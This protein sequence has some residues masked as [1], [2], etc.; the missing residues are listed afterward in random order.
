MAKPIEWSET[1]HQDITQTVRMT[2]TRTWADKYGTPHRVDDSPST[3]DI[4]AA[5]AAMPEG[6]RAEVLREFD[7]GDQRDAET[8]RADLSTARSEKAERERDE[9]RLER[10]RARASLDVV[11]HDLDGTRQELREA[12]EARDRS[13][14]LRDAMMPYTRAAL[15]AAHDEDAVTAARRVV[16]ERDSLRTRCIAAE[17]AL[18]KKGELWVESKTADPPK[19]REY[20]LAEGSRWDGDEIV[21][22]DGTRTSAVGRT[23]GAHIWCVGPWGEKR[24]PRLENVLALAH[25][26][27]LV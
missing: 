17:T 9:A 12:R 7:A 18:T 19:P 14:R 4:V 2:V 27:G 15:D 16:A 5:L 21:D 11:R 1:V 6:E 3:A 23:G 13:T 20:P 26:R 22:L 10:D 8:K 24:F 25:R